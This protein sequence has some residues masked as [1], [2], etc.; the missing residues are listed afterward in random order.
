M[1]YPERNIPMRIGTRGAERTIPTP[2]SPTPRSLRMTA[3]KVM[4]EWERKTKKVAD[5]MRR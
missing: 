1:R 3:R 2:V 4:A 5:A